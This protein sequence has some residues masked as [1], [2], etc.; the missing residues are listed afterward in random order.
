VTQAAPSSSLREAADLLLG[1]CRIAVFAHVDPDADAV[2]SVVGLT[3]GLRALGKEAVPFLSDPAPAYSRFL[4]GTADIRS[5]LPREPF[6]VYVFAD[7]ADIERVGS[8]YS[9]NRDLFDRARILDLDHHRTNPLYGEVNYVDPGAS[10]TSELVFRLLSQMHAPMDAETATALLFGI[11]GDTGAFQNGATTPGSMEVAAAL[12]RL[13]GDVQT[14]AFQLFDRKRFSAAKLWG[15]VL[16]TISLDSER[17]I[18]TAWLSQAML[19]GLGVSLD[20]AEGLT[21]Y[22]RGIEEAQVIMLLKEGEDGNIRVSLRSRPGIDVARIASAL[23]GGGHTQAAGATL[24]DDPEVALKL[25]LETYDR[26]YPR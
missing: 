9:E 19:T 25:L 6:D 18:V 14:I 1:A 7:S 16:S 12:T 4:A 2:G 23:G 22:L 17:H 21:A 8:L 3:G 13:G 20:E 15:E 5:E 10:S 11:Y 24:P 26:F